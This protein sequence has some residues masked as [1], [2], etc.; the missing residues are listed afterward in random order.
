VPVG[1]KHNCSILCGSFQRT[2][3]GMSDFWPMFSDRDF[4]PSIDNRTG[5]ASEL[6]NGVSLLRDDVGIFHRAGLGLGR[7]RA[8]LSLL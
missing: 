1:P 4:Y 5:L 8:L 3:P 7:L 2:F 6:P